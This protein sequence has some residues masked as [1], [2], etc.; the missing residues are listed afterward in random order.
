MA[1]LSEIGRETRRFALELA[2]EWPPP[3]VVVI[4][5]ASGGEGKV[6]IELRYAIGQIAVAMFDTLGGAYGRHVKIEWVTPAHWKKVACGR[7]NLYKPK[8]RKGAYGVLQWA[9]ENGYRGESWDE[10]DALGIAECARR[11]I[12]LLER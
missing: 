2:G 1:R 7:G 10:A 4:E 9:R 12:E 8:T 5:Q 11:E 3:G 6:H